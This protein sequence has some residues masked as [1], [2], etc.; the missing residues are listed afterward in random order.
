MPWT[1]MESDSVK[2]SWP[3]HL[4]LQHPAEVRSH[5][6]EQLA[7]RLWARPPTVITAPVKMLQRWN[8]IWTSCAVLMLSPEIGFCFYGDAQLNGRS[9]RQDRGVYQLNTEGRRV[10]RI[11]SLVMLLDQEEDDS[12]NIQRD[13]GRHS[14]STWS[15]SCSKWGKELSKCY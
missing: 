14:V 11:L 6:A 3:E 12:G 1:E 8:S 7:P 4:P 10:Q 2:E 5:Q 15:E 9:L 13:H